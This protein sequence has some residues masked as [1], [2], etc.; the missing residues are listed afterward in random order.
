MSTHAQFRTLV[1]QCPRHLHLAVAA[2]LALSPGVFQSSASPAAGDRLPSAVLHDI[3]E[4][5]LTL[6]GRSPDEI[7]AALGP[8][9]ER[10][11]TTD[12]P[13]DEEVALGQ[14]W[15]LTFSGTRAKP[16]FEKHQHRDDRLGR[17]SRQSLLQMAF[18]GSKSYDD[19]L[20][21][22]A[23]Y[24]RKFRPAP[25]DLEHTSR[26]VDNLCRYYEAMGDDAKAVTMIFEDIGAL[27]IDVPFNAFR[28]LATHMP[29]L[30]RA[31]R[32]EAAV[33][34]MT[35]HRNALRARLTAAGRSMPAA[36]VPRTT[37]ATHRAGVLHFDPFNDGLLEDAPSMTREE[38]LIERTIQQIQFFERGRPR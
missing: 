21:G 30:Q 18:A 3:A 15:F 27:S 2:L 6:T 29:A 11:R 36:P 17:V 14:A 32:G 31:G 7:H 35:Q 25:E 28:L 8:L 5:R 24:R 4:G 37:S 12:L 23:D 13:P 1:G 34:L 16:W 38:L 26:V 20:A 19:V 10:A 9:V 33:A 22:M